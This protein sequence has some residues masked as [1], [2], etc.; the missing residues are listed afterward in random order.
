ML[1]RTDLDSAVALIRGLPDGA[2]RAEL[3]ARLR[4]LDEDCSAQEAISVIET[5]SSIRFRGAYDA[6]A[7]VAFA[8]AVSAGL[9]ADAPR[10]PPAGW[11]T[12][13]RSFSFRL[14]NAAG[15]P[16]I[17]SCVI[18]AD[19]ITVAATANAQAIGEP[20]RFEYAFR[21]IFHPSARRR[22]R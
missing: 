5:W 14:S 4:R 13:D 9:S 8:A 7:A 6:A 19:A 20:L 11:N 2:V 17:M 22:R 15:A 21:C 12:D 3:E 18:A 16:V 10:G 1:R